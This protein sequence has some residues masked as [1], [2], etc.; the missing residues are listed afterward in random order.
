MSAEDDIKL[1]EDFRQKVE[2]YLFLGY[3][4]VAD[5][6]WP[7]ETTRTWREAQSRPEM[8]DLRREINLMKPQVSKL[9]Y[10][11]GADTTLVQY[12]APAVGGPI[13]KFEILDLITENRSSRTLDLSTV[14]DILDFTI[15]VLRTKAV[16]PV[17]TTQLVGDVTKGLIFIVMPMADDD[18]ALEDVHDTIKLVASDLGMSAQRVDDELRTE[19]ITD[20]I[21]DAISRAEYVVADLSLARPNVY[22]EAGYAHALGKTPIYI[23]R[24]GTKIEF[25]VKDYP[26]LF[27]KNMR[28]LRERLM[29]MLKA[30]R[31]RLSE[32]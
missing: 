15:G 18:H 24:E 5:P 29:A 32:S 16:S 17:S 25:D 1:L 10:A 14:N 13:L 27:Y 7:N 28:S 19:R 6:I 12:P 26:V 11:C 21:L 20:R 4:P 23:A 31:H 30:L 2:Q 8:K 9:L 22:Y 3:V